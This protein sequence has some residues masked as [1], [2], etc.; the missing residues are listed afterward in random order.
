LEEAHDEGRYNS[1][2]PKT[3][4]G[5][6]LFRRRP[7]GLQVLLVHPGGPLWKNKDDGWWSIPKGEVEPGEDLFVAAQREFAEEVGFRPP[8]PFIALTP[9]KLKSGKIVHAWAYACDFDPATLRS[10]RFTMEWPPHSG[11]QSEF[12]EVDRA[13]W[14]T[15]E[16]AK[17]KTSP[18]QMEFVL[19]LAEKRIAG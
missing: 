6:L 15:V 19:E 16:Q 10:N 17:V 1:L 12:T 14:F 9:A 13:A 5:I 8:G 4:A 2:M 3:C 7:H 18:G 11:R